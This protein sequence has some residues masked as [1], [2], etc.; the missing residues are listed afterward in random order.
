MDLEATLKQ[1]FGYPTF[2]QGQRQVIEQVVA[3]RDAFV[4]MPTG[5]GKSLTY[6]LP[7]LLLSGLT[8]V[9]SP[10]IALMQDQVERLRANGIPATFINS[11]LSAGERNRRELA[12]LNGELKLLYVAPERLL[13]EEFLAFLDQAQANV[14][15]S[16]VAVDEAHCVSEWGHDFRPEYRQLG[17]L[18]LQYPTVPMVGLT[19]TATERVR[20]D[21]V[22]QLRLHDPYLHVASFDRPNLHYTV[23]PKTR[24]A[25]RD[26]LEIL[27]A[28]R[29]E[30]VIIYC[31]ARKNVDDLSAALVHDGIRALPYH[32]GLTNE[33]R[34]EHQERFIRDDVPVLVATVA[35]GMGI[36]KP[37][38]RAV[39]HFDM[40]RSLEGYYQESGRA[41]RDGQPAQCILFF[42]YGDR[43]RSEYFISQKASEEE[44]RIARQQLQHMFIYSESSACRRRVLLDYFGEV[45]LADNCGTCD[46]CLQE[47]RDMEDRTVEAR[48]LLWCVNKTRAR[49]GAR[50]IIDILRGA[51]TQRIREYQHDQLP[52]Y[53]AG[54]AL[55]VDEWQRLIRAF[56]QQG[57]L[58]QTQDDRPVLQLTGLSR[59][60]LAQQ[61]TVLVVA[62][63]KL[64]SA[65]TTSSL[66]RIDLDQEEQGLFERLRVW[67]KCVAD[68]QG[69]PPYIV[70]SDQTLCA[71]ARQRPITQQ[72]FL[73]IH[74]VGMRKLEA[75]Y[76]PVVS[77]IR[78]YC[79]PLNLPT[80][81]VL[82]ERPLREQSARGSAMPSSALTVALYRRG[83]RMEEIARERGVA[84]GT[85][86][87]NLLTQFSHGEDID[88]TPLVLPAHYPVIAEALLQLGDE[89]LKLIKDLLGDEYSY[90]E[91][92]IVKAIEGK[93]SRSDL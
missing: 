69:V 85:V 2:W 16:L 58:H 55:S 56:L 30:S 41:G 12:A 87:D 92:R 4:L 32:A 34:A 48:R 10:L 14:G 20:E 24:H 76:E 6:Q 71:F 90:S 74:G 25:Y 49:F 18:R 38:V 66:T 72:D 81:V 86:I 80:G 17:R 43:G 93:K 13:T 7:A 36:A 46:N 31:G 64:V 70:F 75:Y 23:R 8:I 53:G 59:E 57:I 91:I 67:R 35:F 9:V 83:L 15:L 89:R 65:D 51:K 39:I 5:G 68:A 29:N 62:A 78:A 84:I 45:Y 40:P 47:K 52:V 33:E 82:E 11:S 88:L 27:Q 63:P 19:A 42:S 79:E 61:R 54:K 44:Q 37:D 28:H 22:T 26:V 60:V 50:H 21:V 73:R 3:G 1:Y 77:E